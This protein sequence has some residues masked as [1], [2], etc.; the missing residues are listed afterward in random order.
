[1]NNED[2]SLLIDGIWNG[3]KNLITRSKFGQ[4]PRL[5]LKVTYND[6]NYFIGDLDK[7]Q[8]RT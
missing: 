2:E 7:N 8:D 6:K 1:M 5:L 4:M 3:T